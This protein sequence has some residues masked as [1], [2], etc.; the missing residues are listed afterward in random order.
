[1]VD[2]SP[3]LRT[4]AGPQ[5]LDEVDRILTEVRS[6]CNAPDDIFMNLGIAVF[7]IAANI[8]EHA[9]SGLNRLVQL[10]MWVQVRAHDVLVEFT[11]DG[12]PT[13]VDPES[14]D[15]PDELA[16]HGRGLPMARAVLNELSYEHTRDGNHWTLVSQAF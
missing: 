13:D 14:Q 4:V 3:L 12:T 2:V 5:A 8:V 9:A 15:M 10:Q 16:E 1:M 6:K 11:D 7:E